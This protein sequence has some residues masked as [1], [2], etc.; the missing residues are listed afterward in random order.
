ME[1][2]EMF[3]G[4]AASIDRLLFNDIIYIK[5]APND[6]EADQACLLDRAKAGQAAK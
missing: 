6:T 3:G 1:V 5:Y 2:I 4:P